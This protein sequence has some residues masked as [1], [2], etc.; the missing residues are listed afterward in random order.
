MKRAA[1]VSGTISVIVLALG[2]LCKMHHWDGA[3]IVLMTGLLVSIISLA[4]TAVQLVKA[5]VKY[6][7]TYIYWA[8]S[9]FIMIA[10]IV[11]KVQHYKG[12]MVLH[13]IGTG[14]FIIFTI[15][16]AYKLYKHEQG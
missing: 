15:I 7:S 2:A 13:I 5:N 16:L 8:I 3:G 10:G 11:F 9:T 12:S 4:V 6:K 1:F 14:L